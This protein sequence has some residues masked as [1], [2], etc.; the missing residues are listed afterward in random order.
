MRGYLG[1]TPLDVLGQRELCRWQLLL[2]GRG[3]G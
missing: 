2:A 3:A 1:R